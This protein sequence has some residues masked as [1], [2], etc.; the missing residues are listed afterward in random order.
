M[1][2]VIRR[3]VP[4]IDPRIEE[5][6]SEKVVFGVASKRIIGHISFDISHLSFCSSRECCL[7]IGKLPPASMTND[8]CQMIY[9]Q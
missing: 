9:D 3:V 2:R 5:V 6:Q 7:L 1:E 8:K 4:F